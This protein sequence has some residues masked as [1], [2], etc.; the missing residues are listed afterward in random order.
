V[1]RFHQTQKKWLAAQPPASTL[2]DLQRQLDRFRR[3]YNTD[4]H[5]RSYADNT[6]RSDVG[7]Q[8]RPTPPDR[9]PHPPD[10]A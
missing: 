9:K 1:E 4:R 2:A 6:A 3:Y 5:I 8:P 10:H 7:P